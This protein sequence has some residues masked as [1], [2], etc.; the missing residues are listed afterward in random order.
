MADD[1]EE[2]E[3]EKVTWATGLCGCWS[4]PSES[5]RYSVVL[6]ATSTTDQVTERGADIDQAVAVLR[7]QICD[8]GWACTGNVAP[9]YLFMLEREKMLT[10]AEVS[11]N[12]RTGWTT[13]A[14]Q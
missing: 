7:V 5:V 4:L 8:W 12:P 10:K 14:V 1:D 13:E 3:K 6:L 11:K 9:C 2:Q